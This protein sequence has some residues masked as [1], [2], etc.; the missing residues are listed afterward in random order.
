MR[1]LVT[2]GTGYIGS[3]ICVDLLEMGFEVVIVDNLSNSS[4]NIV[5]KI[6]KITGKK[7]DFIHADITNKM[8]LEVVFRSFQID[9]VIHLAGVK[10][11]NDSINN[12]LDYYSENILGTI[13]LLD[14][15]KKYHVNK[16]IFSSSATVYGIP[17]EVPIK[18]EAKLETRNP[19]GLTK[20]AIEQLLGAL[21]QSNENLSIVILRYFNPIGAHESG[22]IGEKP[23]SIPNNLMPFITQVASGE[24]AYLQVFGDNYNTPDGTGI[25]DYIHVADLSKGHIKAL[26]YL[27]NHSGCEIFN[28]GSGSGYSVFEIIE[29]FQLEN[30]II[31]EYEVVGKRDG[32]VASCVADISKAQQVL[33][34]APTKTIE[35]MCR[36]SWRWQQMSSQENSMKRALEKE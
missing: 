29:A 32:D 20:L 12:P 33:E 15:M 27:D 3:Q 14:V 36:D 11:V 34:W 26:Q 2:G 24:R 9:R 19:Y 17:K 13:I 10:S 22:E 5:T 31:L 23:Q 8:E 6:E 7:I 35:E 16:I 30:N 21:A 4:I 25:R 1:I 28:L 18:E